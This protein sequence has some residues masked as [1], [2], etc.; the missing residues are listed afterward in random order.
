MSDALRENT[1]IDKGVKRGPRKRYQHTPMRRNE[2]GLVE[3]IPPD[4]DHEEILKRY[5]A[6]PKTSQIAR[7][8]GV[9]RHSLVA[10]L[11][12][13]DP[14][15]WKAVQ[16]IRAITRKEDSEEGL[17]DA[18]DAL[19]LARARELLRSAQWDL[20][21]LDASNYGQ[22]QEI[23]HNIVPV[24]SITVAPQ[25]PSEIIDIPSGA[26]QQIEKPVP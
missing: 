11:R 15:K 9:R 1:R 3:A 18:N 5:L 20:E 6:T 7:D 16:V 23:T 14:E 21:R 12:S 13:K 19:A 8:L 2:E 10:W 24:L 17:E 22:K 26:V 4:L 25:Q